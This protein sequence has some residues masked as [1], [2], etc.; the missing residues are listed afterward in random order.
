MSAVDFIAQRSCSTVV[1]ATVAAP[2]Q[3]S[4]PVAKLS[5]ASQLIVTAVGLSE[6]AVS[7]ADV[8]AIAKFCGAVGAVA[9]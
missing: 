5:G 8:A 3:S 1:A 7:D 6:Y 9:S 4:V 2:A